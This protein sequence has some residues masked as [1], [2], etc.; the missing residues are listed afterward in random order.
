[1]EKLICLCILFIVISSFSFAQQTKTVSSYG[2][3]NQELS[4]EQIKTERL[5]VKADR[6]VEHKALLNTQFDL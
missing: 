1:M 4:F 6:A 5:K 3:I 2:P